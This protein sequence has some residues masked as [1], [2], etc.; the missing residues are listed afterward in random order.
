[1]KTAIKKIDTALQLIFLILI[2]IAG[3]SLYGWIFLAV[4]FPALG[5]IQLLSAAIRTIVDFNRTDW[6]RK[7]LKTYWML[8]AGWVVVN[9]AFYVIDQIHDGWMFS[10]MITSMPVA[11]WY[12]SKVNKEERIMRENGEVEDNRRLAAMMK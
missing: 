9:G 5:V 3:L 2:V 12:Y 8:V 4:L 1:M 11:I 7:F 6:H 10:M